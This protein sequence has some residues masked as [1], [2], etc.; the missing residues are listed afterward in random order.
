LR[1]STVIVFSVALGIAVD[2]TIH[3]L[4]RYREE[5]RRHGEGAAAVGATLHAVGHPVAWTSAI[6][7][8]GFL[9]NTLSEF[10]AIV[11]FGVLSAITLLVAL[12]VDLWLTPA[13]L[14]GLRGRLGLATD[15]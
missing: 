13:L 6:L 3:F 10:R 7:V 9:I 12:A 8:A 14:L 11:D 2:D 1:A 5:A 4:H 15:P